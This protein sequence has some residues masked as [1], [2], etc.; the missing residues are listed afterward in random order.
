[1]H[2]VALVVFFT[3]CQVIGTM[4][5]S[6]DLSEAKES[7]I[8]METG[9]FCPMGETISCPPS[10]ISSPERQIKHN[11][12]ADADHA[13][14]LPSLG[15]VLRTSSVQAQWTRSSAGSIVPISIASSSV[16]RI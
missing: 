15:A 9:M 1:M 3:F 14:I 13:P 10:L 11:L 12:V 7:A 8:L 6:P 5:A 4:C 2:S 16:L